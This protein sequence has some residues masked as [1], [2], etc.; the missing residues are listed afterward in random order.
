MDPC[1]RRLNNGTPM[2]S[3]EA[4]RKENRK[5]K[6]RKKREA[7]GHGIRREKKLKGSRKNN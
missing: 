3:R 2:H 7:K 5:K 6:G 1:T 4:K